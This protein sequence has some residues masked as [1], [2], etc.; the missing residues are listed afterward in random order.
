MLKSYY[1][2]Y[3]C[4]GAQIHARSQPRS[5]LLIKAVSNPGQCKTTPHVIYLCHLVSRACGC[6]A[7][8]CAKT[9]QEGRSQPAALRSNSTLATVSLPS[10]NSLLQ[11][12]HLTR[13]W[14]ERVGRPPCLWWRH[15]APSHLIYIKYHP[16]TLRFHPSRSIIT[17]SL[18]QLALYLG[19]TQ[20]KVRSRASVDKT[21]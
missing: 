21:H 13:V 19:K 1:Q 11:I 3:V 15:P 18:C 20:Q 2:P 9:Q 16:A 4:C 10:T 7:Y 12:R 6:R 14:P 17:P 5:V 8:G